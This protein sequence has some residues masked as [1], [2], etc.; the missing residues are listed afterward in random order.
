MWNDPKKVADAQ[1]L[2][3]QR[4]WLL[5]V[6]SSLIFLQ[7]NNVRYVCCLVVVYVAINVSTKN[8]REGTRI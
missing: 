6:S 2:S 7:H 4:T 8:K 1:D 3:W 5:E